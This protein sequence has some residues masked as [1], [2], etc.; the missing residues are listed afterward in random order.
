MKTIPIK[1]AATILLSLLALCT[2]EPGKLWQ[3][4]DHLFLLCP[5]STTYLHHSIYLLFTF[6]E[7]SIFVTEM[8]QSPWDVSFQGISRR[9][10]QNVLII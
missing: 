7:T 8:G 3:R 6:T 4:R 1:S 10:I 5:R 9:A 2:G